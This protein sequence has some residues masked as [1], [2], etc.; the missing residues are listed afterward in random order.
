VDRDDLRRHLLGQG[1]EPRVVEALVSVPRDRFVPAAQ[2]DRAWEDHALGIGHGQTISQPFVV[3]TMVQAADVRPGDRVLDV[4]AGSGYQAAVLAACGA[5]VHAV[6][7]IPALAA[8]ARAVLA[9]LGLAVDLR[10]GDG[11]QGVADLAPFDA[12]L[13]AAATATVPPA[14]LAQLREPR[15]SRPGG[16]LVLPLGPSSARFG[17]QELIVVTRSG[18]GYARRKL[19]DVVFVPLVWDGG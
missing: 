1:I 2:R 5:E 13:V 12:I 3:A 16:R 17:S 7:R 10:V 19:L 4:G 14:L 15:P 8:G 6:E 18:E 9:G 11:T